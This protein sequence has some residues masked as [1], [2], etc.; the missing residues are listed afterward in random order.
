MKSTIIKKDTKEYFFRD[1]YGAICNTSENL[2]EKA[3]YFYKK[4]FESG[5]FK[6]PYQEGEWHHR[7]G[8]IGD[9]LNYDYYDITENQILIQQRWTSR[10]KY[11]S[12][13]CCK[14]YHIVTV[15]E[16]GISAKEAPKHLVVKLCKICPELGQIIDIINR[17]E[18]HPLIA[19]ENLRKAKESV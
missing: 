16:D 19:A 15:N 9:Y 8:F 2:K 18:K 14:A 13:V 6:K 11:G 17:E 12:S 7:H 10:N 4:K 5:K 1:E 3:K